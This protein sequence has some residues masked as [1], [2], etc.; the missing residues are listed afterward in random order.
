MV[1]LGSGLFSYGVGMIPGSWIYSKLC[2]GTINNIQS[3]YVHGAQQQYFGI[4]KSSIS[5][6]PTWQY[7]WHLT[8]SIYIYVEHNTYNAVHNDS[9]RI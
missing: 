3:I 8:E 5:N 2:I 4:Y 9:K 7:K 1:F 6:W